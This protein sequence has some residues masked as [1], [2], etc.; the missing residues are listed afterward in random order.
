MSGALGVRWGPEASVVE[1]SRAVSN[2]IG[3]ILL[4]SVLLL[5]LAGYQ[6]QVVPQETAQSEF[7]HHQTVQ[8]DLIEFRNAVFETATDDGSSFSSSSV[9]SV[10][11]G[12]T[13]P[14]RTLTV[15]P[16]SSAGSLRTTDSYNVTVHNTR[17]NRT[18][19]VPT[20][21]VEYTP[22]YSEYRVGS[23]WYENSMVYLD[24]RDRGTTEPIVLADQ[25]LAVDGRAIRVI[26][27]QNEIDENGIGSASIEK[28]AADA[29]E[30]HPELFEAETRRMQ[31]TLPTRL[32]GSEYWDSELDNSVQYT[33]DE[34]AYESG[35]HELEVLVEP[36]IEI[37]TVGFQSGPTENP[38]RSPNSADGGFS[39]ANDAEPDADDLQNAFDEMDGSGT[40]ADPF[41]ITDDYELQAVAKNES[42]LKKNYTLGTNIDA[43]QTDQ[44]NDGDG[45]G[46][47]GNEST[48]F[49]GSFDGNGYVISEPSVERTNNDS[50]GLFGVLD[51]D[52]QIENV[53]L[54]SVNISGDSDVGG[55]VGTSSG[56]VET[57]YVTG[58]VDGDESVGGVVGNNSGTIQQLDATTDVE[59]TENVGGVAGYNN[60]D[61]M[62]LHASGAVDGTGNVGGLVGENNGTLSGS[63]AT[64]VVDG[65][66]N[67]G[68]LV[69]DNSEDLNDAYW[70]KGTT[71]QDDAVGDGDDENTKGFGDTDDATPAA[72]MIG[73][74]DAEDE[75]RDLGDFD[76]EWRTLEHPDDYPLLRR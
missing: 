30:Q 70:D 29:V 13:H 45:F 34:D 74:F 26:P 53:G 59:G 50:V 7:E 24:E 27:T 76:T 62:T 38:L 75:M 67:V 71:N 56:E 54:E 23:I 73:E 31:I 8:N 55:V 3:F 14:S 58:D 36:N 49:S 47:I 4:F 51:S 12:T 18:E 44:W 46:P 19:A 16:P 35:V 65:D 22:Q 68:G 25:Q 6:A 11:L 66:T 5:A 2:L 32:N 9:S 39:D 33:I 72:K 64:G 63:Y 37:N 48:P 60:G 61:I 43:S 20:R 21:F 69:G 52:G 17:T 28:Y 57:V 10:T 15:G 40:E 41:V 42:T 1:D